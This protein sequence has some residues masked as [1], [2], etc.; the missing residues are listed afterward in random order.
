MTRTTEGVIATQWS[1]F[2][3]SAA[4]ILLMLDPGVPERRPGAAGDPPHPALGGIVL[5]LMGWTSIKLD[6]AT[7]LVAS[8]AL[9]LSVDDTFHCLIQFHQQRKTRRF[10][11]E[12]VR[13]L[14][15]DRGPACCSPAW[16]W[17][18]DSLALRTSE[19]EPFV[20]FGTMVAIATAGS[21]L[22]NLVL[23]PACLTLGERRRRR[24]S[25]SARPE[26][27]PETVEPAAA[28]PSGTLEP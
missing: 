25:S 14:L 24:R 13:Q 12:P 15:R 11:R 16:P 27:S 9:G 19:F 23:L 20:N 5:G 4:G 10:R 2:G 18:S 26:P 28:S 17:P 3:W 6:I 21:T 1:T 7:A 8:V 22:G